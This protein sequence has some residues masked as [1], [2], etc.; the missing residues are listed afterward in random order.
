MLVLPF[1]PFNQT[2]RGDGG[3]HSD[4]SVQV[5]VVHW[6]GQ[7]RLKCNI[8]SSNPKCNNFMSPFLFL[9]L[10]L[11]GNDFLAVNLHFAVSFIV[12]TS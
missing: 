1:L 7:E 2:T 4:L 10:L 3:Q 8:R 9:N 6:Q 12:G 5:T 11:N